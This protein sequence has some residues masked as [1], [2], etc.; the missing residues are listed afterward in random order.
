MK[1]HP[2]RGAVLA[3]IILMGTGPIAFTPPAYA[4]T[5]AR[6]KGEVEAR[7]EVRKDVEYGRVDAESLKLDLYLPAEQT[8]ALRPGL[9]FIHG[10]GW[11]GGDKQ[12]FADKA[13]E[14]AGRGY[15]AISVN[16]RLAPKHRYPAAIE[17]VQRAVR[18][19]RRNADAYHV[20]PERIGAMGASAGGHLAS[21]LGV[22]ETRGLKEPSDAYSARVNCVVDYFGRMDLTL[23]PIGTG[24]TDYRPAFLGKSKAEAPELYAEASPIT[25]VDAHTAPF[26]IVQGARDKQ[27]QPPQ[28]ERMLEALDRAGVEASLLLLSGAG[29][30]FGGAPA[31]Q[32]WDSAKAFLD[33][34][35]HPIGGRPSP[36]NTPLSGRNENRREKS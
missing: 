36:P 27:V 7:V 34:H 29:H 19:L 1:T 25:Y 32:A 6:K 5:T 16:Y 28:S 22:R 18:W 35:L 15:V 13:Q 26:L 10:G 12:E 4:D 3:S 30:G 14:M 21:M 33:R 20:D 11:S 24:W 31:Q 9:V 8:A 17:D 23:E 2:R